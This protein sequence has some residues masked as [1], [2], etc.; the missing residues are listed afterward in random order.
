[1]WGMMVR[2]RVSDILEKLYWTERTFS[3]SHPADMSSHEVQLLEV[4][5]SEVD[6]DSGDVGSLR[7]LL[8]FKGGTGTGS[9]GSTS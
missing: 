1:M 7:D 3:Q 2:E 8:H 9:K 6:D 4:S 5:S